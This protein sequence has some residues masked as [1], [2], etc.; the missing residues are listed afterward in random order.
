MLY[1][2]CCKITIQLYTL[3]G[4]VNE[5]LGFKAPEASILCICHITKAINVSLRKY[6]DSSM[7]I[8]CWSVVGDLSD[9][10]L[11][12]LKT[13]DF[14]DKYTEIFL[15]IGV[16]YKK[17]CEITTLQGK[18]VIGN[19]ED[20][21][22]PVASY[23]KWVQCMKNFISVWRNR[24]EEENF[25]H[26]DILLHEHQHKYIHRAMTV[27]GFED[28]VINEQELGKL[29]KTFQQKETKVSTI[30]IRKIIEKNK[31]RW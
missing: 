25:T 15:S 17:H 8:F 6:D 18:Q 7:Q 12:F 20:N 30:L 28:L 1:C 24:I 29:T 11:Q 10:L 2:D 5:I 27:L 13:H 3:Q 21:S 14:P 23:L 19:I 4:I 22:P 16:L 9:E 26:K 31:T